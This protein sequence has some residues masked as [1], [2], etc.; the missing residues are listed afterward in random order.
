VRFGD[1]EFA[2]NQM[3][4]VQ[5]E[6]VTFMVSQQP[7]RNPRSVQSHL[8]RLAAPRRLMNQTIERARS[9]QAHG[10]LLPR[11]ITENAI[12]QF[13]RG[14]LAAEPAHNLLVTS[15]AERMD[16]IDGLVPAAREAA[17]AKAQKIISTGVLPA[18][19]RGLALVYEQL[20]LTTDDAGGWR[21]HDGEA[22]YAGQLT[23]EN[24]WCDSDPVDLLGQLHD[25]LFRARCVAV[26][27]GLYSM[28]WTRL[29]AI[30]YGI[31][32]SEVD[33]C[34]VGPGQACS[35]RLSRLQREAL[36][37]QARSALG[38]RFAIRKFHDVVLH[39]GGA[40]LAV[41]RGGCE[42][43]DPRAVG[44]AVRCAGRQFALRRNVPITSARRCA[45]SLR[46]SAAAADSSTSAA[47]LCVT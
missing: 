26:D 13:G 37:A 30:D 45:W 16:R 41:P 19:Q 5:A 38:E 9:A 35:S 32:A 6:S 28:K 33:R 20:P 15:V 31:T 39:T 29:Q 25:A 24:G 47:L 22:L 36:R 11:F 43:R 18:W 4:G 23:A 1:D 7:L 46:L 27:T 12:A 21:L 14:C 44:R 10:T 42:R 2:F 34:V 17:R 3:S 40:P 8:E